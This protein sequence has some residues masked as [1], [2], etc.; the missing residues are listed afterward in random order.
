MSEDN[1]EVARQLL[2]AV[3]A[4]DLSRV[5]ELTDPDVEW[6]SFFALQGE[7]YHGHGGV[8]QYVTDIHEAFEDLRPQVDDLLD[9]GEVVIGIGS[10]HYRGRKSG[11]ETDSAAGWMFRF[12]NGKVVGFRAFSEPE[13]RLKELGLP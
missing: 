10:V 4:R 5:L 11:V 3:S 12:R 13:Q 1:V 2:E 7:A 9:G 6:H 8:R